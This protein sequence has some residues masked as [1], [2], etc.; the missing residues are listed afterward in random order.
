MS[1][2]APSPEYNNL[3]HSKRVQVMESCMFALLTTNAPPSDQEAQL[4]RESITLLD[5]RSVELNAE[6]TRPQQERLAM[7]GGSD[8][9]QAILSPARRTPMDVW[10]VIFLNC[11]PEEEYI[12]PKALSAPLLLCQICR[13]LRELAISMP[14]LWTS[15][16]ARAMLFST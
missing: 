6:I 5:V 7:K 12:S 1:V 16:A 11:L 9:H 15:I 2:C 8:A 10:R 4:I 13:T 14:I 3:F